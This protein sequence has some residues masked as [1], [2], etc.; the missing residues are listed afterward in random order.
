MKARLIE[1]PNE[2]SSS[3]VVKEISTN[4]FTT[5]FH[6]HDYC[7]LN[8]VKKSFGKRIVGDCINNF[9]EG[10]LVLMSPNLPHVWYN[11]PEILAKASNSCAQ[12]IVTYFPIDFL[13][14]LSN[15]KI[16][17]SKRQNLFNRADRGLFFYGETKRKVANHL[18]RLVKLSGLQMVIEFLNV[19]DLLLHSKEYKLLAS[20]SY[21]HSFN[22][23]DTERMHQ[24]YKFIMNNFKE[25]ISLTTISSIANMT[26]PAFCNFFKMRMQMSFTR[27]LN[28]I[29]IGHACKL[30]ENEDTSISDVCYESGYQNFTNFNKFFKEIT[31]K[32]PGKYRKEYLSSINQH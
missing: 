11:D 29:R 32:T 31:G 16:L 10:D 26:P 14:K 13:D 30:L 23:R 18:E 20:V 5:P 6:F 7:E 9:S 4:H 8:Y 24:I 12:A 25:P 19:V 1:L 28:E 17:F 3:I 15:D 27:F 22:K 2:Q 21:R